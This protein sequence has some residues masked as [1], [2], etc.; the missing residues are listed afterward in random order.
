[1]EVKGYTSG[2]VELRY[3]IRRDREPTA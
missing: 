2:T 1:M 3:E